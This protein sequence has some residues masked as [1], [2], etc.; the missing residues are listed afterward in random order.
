MQKIMP[1]KYSNK[2]RDILEKYIKD[3]RED[4]I[5]LE[6]LIPFA[7]DPGGDLFCFSINT[8]DNGSIYYWSHEYDLDED[9][10]DYVIKISQSMNNFISNLSE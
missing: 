6:W 1:I 5:L 8:E 7:Y 4:V 10:E 9:P 2:G 3:F